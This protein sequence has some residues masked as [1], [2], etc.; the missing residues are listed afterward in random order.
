MTIKE[1]LQLPIRYKNRLI[2]VVLDIIDDKLILFMW[3][4]SSWRYDCWFW[5]LMMELY[6]L[7]DLFLV[8]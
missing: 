3:F 4:W 6:H 7:N 8:V 1:E 2:F 5:W